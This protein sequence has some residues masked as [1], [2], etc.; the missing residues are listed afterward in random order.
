MAETSEGGKK[1]IDNNEVPSITSDGPQMRIKVKDECLELGRKSENMKKHV[2]EEVFVPL[3]MGVASEVLNDFKEQLGKALSGDCGDNAVCVDDKESVQKVLK[4][5]Q[6]WQRWFT[7]AKIKDATRMKAKTKEYAEEK[8]W[9]G[10]EY[11]GDCLRAM[12]VCRGGK[13]SGDTIYQTWLQ[14]KKAFCIKKG[15]GRLKNNFATAGVLKGDKHQ[16]P[17]DMLMNITLNV[18]GC[19]P[20]P[21]EIQVHHE[22]ILELKESRDHLLYEIYRAES[23]SSL[24]GAG[25]ASNNTKIIKK[26]LEEKAKVMEKKDKVL[27][28]KEKVMEE[29]DKVIEENAKVIEEKDREIEKLKQKLLNFY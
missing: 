11:L 23:I 27:E 6:N 28:K 24:Q 18:E 8:S 29:K 7:V 26:I 15:N 12:V 3:I 2:D 13:E 4:E 22:V 14:L 9:P 20:M 21:A 16:K 10:S 17:P 19:M 25:Q 1:V 5:N